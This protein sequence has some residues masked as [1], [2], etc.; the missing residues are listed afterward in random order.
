M[1][2]GGNANHLFNTGGAGYVFNRAALELFY[3]S[4]DEPFCAPHRHGSTRTCSSRTASRTVQQNWC[5]LTRA[6]R[7]ARSAS[8]CSTRA[9]TS[10]TAGRP[11]D[12]VPHSFDLLEGLDYFSP[13]STVFPLR[14]GPRRAHGRAG[15]IDVGNFVNFMWGATSSSGIRRSASSAA[16]ALRAFFLS[17]RRLVGFFFVV[18][19]GRRRNNRR[20]PVARRGRQLL[21]GRVEGRAP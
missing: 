10:P 6:T 3:D 1:K 11:K 12:W 21:H 17:S 19:A 7:R 4:L 16:R 14:A 13:E 20:G 8:T 15:G 2:V 9:S 18:P 5:Q